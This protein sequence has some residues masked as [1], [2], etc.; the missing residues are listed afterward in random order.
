[1]LAVSEPSSDPSESSTC[2]DIFL[3][4][5]SMRREKVDLEALPF[6]LD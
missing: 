4:I 6:I 1:M 5:I 2:S 3:Q